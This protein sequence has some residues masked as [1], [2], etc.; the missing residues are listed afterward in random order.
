M[1]RALT[2]LVAILFLL[3]GILFW[4]VAALQDSI[5]SLQHR[6]EVQYLTMHNMAENM[7]RLIT[8]IEQDHGIQR[9]AL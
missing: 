1:N 9:E 6:Q 5:E 3:V 4:K 7:D 8:I 2:I